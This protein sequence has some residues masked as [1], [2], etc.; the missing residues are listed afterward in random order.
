MTISADDR[1]RILNILYS[2]QTLYV[3]LARGEAEETD[4]AYRRRPVVFSEPRADGE[5]RYVTND[6]PVTFPP[7]A[8]DAEPVT[9]AII[10]DAP[11]GG[12]VKVIERMERERRPQ[13]GDF[14][15]FG[16]GDLRIEV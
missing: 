11:E 14:V 2:G 1:E 15:V 8:A 6:D 16:P 7:Y 10:W 5:R 13:R 12:S 4:A 3:G 9:H